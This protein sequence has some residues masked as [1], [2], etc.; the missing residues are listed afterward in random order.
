M[1]SRCH[2]CENEEA[3]KFRRTLNAT[4]EIN[5]CPIAKHTIPTT[6]TPIEPPANCPY[7]IASTP[8]SHATNPTEYAAASGR[9]F[10]CLVQSMPASMRW[11]TNP[12]RVRR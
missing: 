3:A 10:A 5:A 9:A 12:R 7:R 4:I 2:A 8:I 6:V 11:F 1:L